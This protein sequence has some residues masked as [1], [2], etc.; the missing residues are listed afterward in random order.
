MY[1]I[2]TVNPQPQAPAH[3]PPPLPLPPP[4]PPR[5]K[6]MIFSVYKIQD[7]FFTDTEIHGIHFFM[8]TEY[9]IL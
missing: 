5:N 3:A 6:G 7:S 1:F 4:L 2:V 8:T 9:Y